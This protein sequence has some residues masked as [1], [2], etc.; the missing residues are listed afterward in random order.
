MYSAEEV[1]RSIWWHYLVINVPDQVE[2]TDTG[3]LY[4]TGGTN[5]D[6]LVI[7]LECR[8]GT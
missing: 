2:F 8:H 4:I 5:K 3:L 1:S 7:R 6:G